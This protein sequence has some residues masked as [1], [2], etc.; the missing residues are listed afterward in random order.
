MQARNTKDRYLSPLENG[1]FEKKTKGVWSMT[2]TSKV[3]SN[4]MQ[5]TN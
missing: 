2:T 3:A 1:H 5:R 4:Y